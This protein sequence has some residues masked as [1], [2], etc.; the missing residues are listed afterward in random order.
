MKIRMSI[1]IGLGAVLILAAASGLVLASDASPTEEPASS[2]FF[3][4][5]LQQAVDELDGKA[6]VARTAAQAA[7]TQHYTTDP[8]LWPECEFGFTR[9][10][11]QWPGC[12][13]TSDPNNPKWSCGPEDPPWPTKDYTWD[14]GLWPK[15]CGKELTQ[16]PGFWCE[17]TWTRDPER[18]PQCRSDYTSNPEALN[19]CQP[20]YTRDPAQWDNCPTEPPFYTED[21]AV[22]KECDADEYTSDPYRWS[23]CHFTSDPGNPHC[24]ERPFP[25]QDYTSNPLTWKECDPSFTWD[26]AQVPCGDP[27]YTSGDA[28]PW[29][30]DPGYT[31][32]SVEWHLCHFTSDPRMWPDACGEPYATQDFTWD[33]KLWP[34]SC[35]AELTR[36][37][38]FWCDLRYTTE[39]GAWPW[40]NPAWTWDPGQVVCAPG[41]TKD[42]ESWKECREGLYTQEVGVWPACEY[43]TGD[44]RV[45]PECHYTSEPGLW[46]ACDEDPP[47]ATKDYTTDAVLWPECE[48]PPEYTTDPTGWPEC[49]YTY[50]APFWAECEPVPGDSSD[51]G[52]APDSTNHVGKA[53]TAYPAGGPPGVGARY[54]A[55]F[56]PLTGLPKGP[57]HVQPR[58][59]SWLGERVTLEKDADQLPDEDA[60]TNI[61]PRT[62]T[63]DRD[64]ADDGAK[65]PVPAPHC[66]RTV[67]K[68]TVTIAAG[69]PK[70]GRYV[71][72]WFDW[73]RDGDWE[74]AFECAKSGDAPEWAVQNQLVTLGPGTYVLETP[75]YLPWNPPGGNISEIWMRISL[76]DQVAPRAPATSLADGRGPD[77]GYK[78]GETEDYYF[79]PSCPKPVADFVWDPT[80]V[81]AKQPVSFLDT[82]T[83]AL[84]LT[85]SWDF[86]GLGSSSLQNPTFTFSSAGTY[87][88]S[89]KATNACGPDTKTK[90]VPVIDCPPQDPAYDIYL[91]DNLADDGSVP[92]TGPFWP[93]PDIWVRNDGDCTVTAHQN[94]IAG[95]TTTICVRVRNRLATTVDNITVQVYYASAAMG[96]SWPGSF[97]PVGSLTIASLAGGAVTVKPVSWSVPGISGHFCLLARANAPKDPIGSGTDTVA[98]VDHVPNNNNIAQKNLYAV[99]YPQVTHCGFFSTAEH[100]DVVVFDAVNT[101]ATATDVDIEFDS[102]DF[103]P[104]GELIVEPG[105]LWGRWTTLTNFDQSGSTLLPTG[106]PA[107]MG[108]V[109]MTGHEAASLTMTITAEIDESFTISV[110]EI[111]GSKAVGGI[112]F[113]RDLPD[114]VYLPVIMKKTQP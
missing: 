21:T 6:R 62:D 80:P 54:P 16:D 70:V 19:W 25:T 94:P 109:E 44:A 100:T 5:T 30:V 98:P 97:S 89:L 114:C 111:S 10:L 67:F 57:L 91:K 51:L 37:Q 39:P 113:V 17:P 72:V 108:G 96:L 14:S 15:D 2:P 32:N 27:K 40:C 50:D 4:V 65:V 55:V 59:D 90:R 33:N 48:H 79:K 76:A 49:H 84:P 35:G 13:Y 107:T 63:P 112:V 3:D 12:H 41:Y 69:A 83:S 36:D 1:L 11:L 45:W 29:C 9:D 58:A 95:S 101:K 56:D 38:N 24:I 8:K 31:T 7:P 74:D 81:C 75:A 110:T 23:E 64:K 71:N 78:Y 20:R 18:F 86:D 43:Y 34:K 53:M 26:P 93:S 61:D 104:G 52:D 60:V 77:A 106:F 28:W 66:V 68:Y 102:N 105:S 42:P 85:W 47:F 103:P 99:D 82:S 87:D 46:K 22:W 73:N 88:V 92:S